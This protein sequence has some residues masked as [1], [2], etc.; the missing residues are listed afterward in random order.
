MKQTFKTEADILFVD[1]ET[2]PISYK[3]TDLSEKM[4]KLWANKTKI[5]KK[6]NKSRKLLGRERGNHGRIWENHC[7]WFRILFL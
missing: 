1:I 3:F 2:V 6:R 5:S 4:Q 7:Y